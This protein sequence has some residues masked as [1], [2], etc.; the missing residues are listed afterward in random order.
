MRP[1]L[2]S[3]SLACLAF[4]LSGL[5]RVAH[6]QTPTAGDILQKSLAYHDPQGTWGRFDGGFTIQ[7]ETPDKPVRTSHIKIDQPA[8]YFGIRIV[9]DGAET[10]LELQKADCR[11][12][13]NGSEDFSEEVADEYRLTCE[14]ARLWR[15]YYSF[16][17]G[18][19][20]KLHDPGTNLDPK[21]ERR[22]FH[23]KT[24]WVLRVTYDPETGSDTWYFYF[25]PETFA[26]SAYQFFH[27]PAKNDGEYILLEGEAQV[28]GMRLPR[29]RKW[30]TN[31]G[32]RY[33]G[34]DTLTGSD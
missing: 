6:A 16:L 3:L 4:L 10:E 17:Y 28:G 13:Y 29:T 25:N 21:V 18:L 14:R 26:L 34:T 27:D 2:P 22:A 8:S 33:L 24:Y 9:Q 11:L 32:D 5:A 19:P 23:G 20:M 1:I 30:Y 31:Q 7:M 15:D 12:R